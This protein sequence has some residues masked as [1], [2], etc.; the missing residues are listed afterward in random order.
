MRT[1]PPER[2]RPF[3]GGW[4][5]LVPILALAWTRGFWAPDEPRYGQIAREAWESGSF[6]VLHLCGELYP[7]KPPLVYWLAGLFGRISAWSEFWMRMPS[8]LATIGSAWCVGRLA[9]RWIGAR[10][11]AWATATYLGTLLVVWL[12]SRLQLDPLMS[13]CVLAALLF[14][15]DDS[16]GER[17]IVRRSLVVGVLLGLSALVKGPPAWASFGFACLVWRFLPEPLRF[18]PGRPARAWVGLVALALLP[19]LAWA[20]LAI[21]AEPA[22]AEPLLFGQHVGRITAGD[23]H[24]GPVWYHLES[25]PLYFLPWT[26]LFLAG[27]A[28]AWRA[29]RERAD[30]GLVRMAAWFAVVFVFF[31]VIPPKRELYLLPVYPSGAILA[32]FTL[33]RAITRGRLAAW[34]GVPTA[35]ALLVVGGAFVAAPL[36]VARAQE[37][38]SA[39]MEDVREPLA[40]ARLAVL[41]GVVLLLGGVAAIVA[42]VR[43]RVA[44][45]A[46]AV[47]VS[48]ALAFTV[49]AFTIQPEIDVDKCA[50][51]LARIAAA[52]P[53]KPTVLACVGVRPEGIRFYGGGPAQSISIAEALERDGARFLGLCSDREFERLPAD[54]RSR[55]REVDRG[56]VGRHAVL[57]LVRAAP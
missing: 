14:Y 35:L 29:W 51:T 56:R 20:L 9:R 15:T 55:V 19:V 44:L 54:V 53:E 43:A 18:S 52:R 48:L 7:D 49:A 1:E 25:L 6:L 12:G 8:I 27:C 5:W 31:S 57:V 16:G 10:V 21:R 45:F 40:F 38:G 41:P 26:F 37:R 4:Y 11:G 17:A 36:V 33:D 47:G 39:W 42:L 32:A 46:N 22:L 3:L 30:A 24:P 2:P 28:A 13:F 34:I 23:K 50:R